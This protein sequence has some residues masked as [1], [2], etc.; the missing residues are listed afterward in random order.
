MSM[1]TITINSQDT[2]DN[3]VNAISNAISIENANFEKGHYNIHTRFN[4]GGHVCPFLISLDLSVNYKTCPILIDLPN[5]S[6]FEDET[7][8]EWDRE[9]MTELIRDLFAFEDLASEVHTSISL[10]QAVTQ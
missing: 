8:L 3:L 9:M 10:A 1:Q 7:G 5:F 2:L 4:L 6:I